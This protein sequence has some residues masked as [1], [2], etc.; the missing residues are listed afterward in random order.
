MVYKLV[1]VAKNINIIKWLIEEV[2]YK[3]LKYLYSKGFILNEMCYIYVVKDLKAIQ[4]LFNNNISFDGCFYIS[5]VRN[6]NIEILKWCIENGHHY[7]YNAV[8]CSSSVQ[9][10][11]YFESI[12]LKKPVID[13]QVDKLVKLA[14]LSKKDLINFHNRV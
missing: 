12:N 2:G 11:K 8:S 13:Y 7:N 14:L 1:V 6:D 9:M 5:L 4:F 3:L 10:L